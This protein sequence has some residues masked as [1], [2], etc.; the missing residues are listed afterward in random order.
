MEITKGGRFKVVNQSNSTQSQST[1]VNHFPEVVLDL[2]VTS[3][4]QRKISKQ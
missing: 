3:G 1:S 2:P 4:M